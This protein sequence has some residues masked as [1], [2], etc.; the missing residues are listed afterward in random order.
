MSQ[1]PGFVHPQFS[2]HVCKLKK[3]LYGLKQSPRAWFSQL[4]S[5]LLALGFRGSRPQEVVI[6]IVGGMTYE[7]SHSVA[8]QNASKSGIRFIL[9]GS[10]V[11]NSKGFPKD[12]EEAQRKAHSSTVVI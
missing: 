10:L 5:H 3:A 7:E 11:L 2:N 1:P 4:S 12:L 6:F 8:L 9:G